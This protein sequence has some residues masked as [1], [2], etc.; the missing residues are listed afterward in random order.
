MTMDMQ[1]DAP[2]DTRGA[3]LAVSLSGTNLARAS[4]YNQRVVLQAIRSSSETTRVELSR[5]TG[6]TAPTIAN[7]TRRLMDAGLV[8]EIGR[9][10]GPRGQPAIRL[11]IDALGCVA[12]GLNIDRDHLTLVA[13][14]LAGQVRGRI[15]RDIAF[16]LPEDVVA[17][18][19]DGLDPLLAEAGVGRD[20][21]LG[22]GVTLPDDLGSIALPGRPETYERWAELSVA[23]LLAPMLPWPVLV[24]NDAAA[25]AIGEAQS[26]AGLGLA[27]FFYI[28]ISSGLGGGLM[29]DRHYVEGANRRSAE[30]GLLPDVTSSRP[31]ALVQ[32]V[33][34][35]SA[36][37]QYLAQAGCDIDS[38][39]R[40]DPADP[41]V[42][43]VIDRW[44]EDA[45]RALIA[46]IVNINCLID[47]HAIII[48]GRLPDFLVDDL[49][50]RLTA[51]LAE[52]RL[53]AVAPISRAAMAG[54]ASAIGAAILPFLDQ[55]LPSDAILMQAGR[56]A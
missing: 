42:K 28:F 41:A 56:A 52:M 34:S 7:I 26:G 3:R 36:L 39:S 19:A 46:P 29:I 48:G 51:R 43:R 45:T 23:D 5:M 2:R 50:E 9:L 40:I 16:A 15:S 38:P 44:V 6:L 49:I 37:M 11:T 20:R 21:V 4:D 17:F 53:P 14:D 10:Q 1:R 31:G 30:L 8:K 47:P 27:S 25:A 54:D 32:D 35:L 12:I 55:L 22:V 33:V 18:V 24:D 13:L